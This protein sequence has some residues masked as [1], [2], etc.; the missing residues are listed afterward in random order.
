MQRD[1]TIGFTNAPFAARLGPAGELCQPHSALKR[2]LFRREHH[3]GWQWFAAWAW[4]YEWRKISRI[5]PAKITPST[6]S[7]TTKSASATHY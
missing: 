5:A 7:A 4:I 1:T 2:S 3:T 6:M